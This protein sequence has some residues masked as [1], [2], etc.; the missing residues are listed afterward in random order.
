M[1]VLFSSGDIFLIVCDI[2]RMGARIRSTLSRE[3]EIGTI[4][5]EDFA[6]WSYNLHFITSEEPWSYRYHR[7]YGCFELVYTISGQVEHL[8]DGVWR[9]FSDGDLL[10]VGEEDYHSVRGDSFSYA[11]LIIPTSVW[12]ERIPAMGVGD[13]LGGP[14]ACRGLT[15]T[16]PESRR[17]VVEAH[18]DRLFRFQQSQEGE[19]QLQRFLG[20]L[21]YEAYWTED[22]GVSVPV[23]ADLPLWWNELVSR[24][25]AHGDIPS[26]PRKMAELAGRSREHVARTCRRVTG[27]SP[28]VWLNNRRLDRAALLLRKSNRDIADIAYSLDF[29]SI[30]HF[31]RLFKD[32]FGLPPMR[33][34][35]MYGDAP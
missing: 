20:F 10:A 18:M 14:T 12:N 2:R 21:L 35:S 19:R 1:P 15:V 28:S 9:S 13:P 22:A 17:P 8:L 23:E 32:R 29:G 25:D 6:P 7:H 24:V 16:V 5:G 4:R 30:P 27:H 26:D 11:N 31:Y 34:R 33:Y 3:Q